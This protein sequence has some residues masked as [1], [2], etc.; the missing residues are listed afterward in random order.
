MNK[1][2]LGV[3]ILSKLIYLRCNSIVSKL[4]QPQNSEHTVRNYIPF[5]FSKYTQYGRETQINL[6]KLITS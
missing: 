4:I 2:Q 6:L 5:Y 1:G 3:H